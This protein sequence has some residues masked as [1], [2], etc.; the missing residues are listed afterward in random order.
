MKA[1]NAL[2]RVSTGAARAERLAQQDGLSF[3]DRLKKMTPLRVTGW[4]QLLRLRPARILGLR[5]PMP[6]SVL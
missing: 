4:R 3:R 2:T 6:T 5:S 1:L